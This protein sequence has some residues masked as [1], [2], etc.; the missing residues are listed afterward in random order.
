MLSTKIDNLVAFLGIGVR[1]VTFYV[2][3]CFDDGVLTILPPFVVDAPFLC[4]NFHNS[5]SRTGFLDM[6]LSHL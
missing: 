3:S 1:A 4:S 2:E 5:D 6:N